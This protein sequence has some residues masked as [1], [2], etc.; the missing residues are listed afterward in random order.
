MK[1]SGREPAARIP[2]PAPGRLDAPGIME[3]FAHRMM[4][5]VAKDEHTA[6]GFDVFQALAF[7]VRDRLMERWFRTQSA[8]YVA[9][10]KR[11]Y[12]LS[13]E[14]L[15]GRAL[16]HNVINLRAR[17][18]YTDA[19]R[20]VGYDLEA[21]QEQEW[22]AGLGNG[23]LGRLAA[24]ILDS[25]ATLGLPFY[26]YGIR[27]EYGIFQQ[28][29]RDGFQVES[30]D[31]W[32]RYGN[33][34]E[35]PRADAIFPVRFYGRAEHYRD[36]RGS[37]RAAWVDTQE[38]WA[39]AYDTPVTGFGNDTVNTLRL[40][41]AKSS[42]EFDLQSFNAGE[43]VRA[44]EDKTSSENISKVLY[45]PDD[46]YAG[47]ELRLKQQYFFV[48]ATLQDVLRRFRKRSGRSWRELPDKVR[49]QLNDTHPVLAIPELMRLLVD[50]HHVDWDQAWELTQAVFAYTNHTVLPEALEKWPA[51]LLGRLLPRHLEIVEEIDRRFRASVALQAGADQGLVERTAV[52][53][54]ARNVRMAHL[55]FVGSRFVNGV[56]ALHTRI[57]RESTFAELDRVAPGR[58]QN[59]TNG[60][61]PRRWLLLANP[62]LAS[63]VT[64][65]IGDRWITDLDEL[66][67]LAPLAED[68][69]FREQWAALKRV[70]K[71]VLAD[72]VQGL[73]GLTLDPDSLFDFQVKRI[74]EYKRQL[75]NVLHV[76]ALHHRIRDGRYE[77]GPRTV[78]FA[79]KAAPGY[80]MAKRIIKLIHAVAEMVAFDSASSR[81]LRV[82]FVPNYSVSLAEVIFPACELSEQISTAGTEA[83]GTGNM[84]AALNGAL[85]IG[86][87]DGANVEIRDQVG[88]DNFFLFGN[89][90]EQ[91]AALRASGDSPGPF[92]GRSEALRRAIEAI[93]SGPLE[94]TNPGAFR[95]IVEELRGPDR[96][97]VCADFDSYAEAQARVADR[98]ATTP[99]DWWRMSVLNVAGM[100]TFSSDRTTRA[101]AEEIW[102]AQPVR[103]KL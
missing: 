81:L 94:W 14:F 59:K 61:T 35:I 12:Y 63:L 62:G 3:T 60:I 53:D 33:P 76:I 51:D 10:V 29:I 8:Y 4:Y 88:A 95:P 86:T 16:V 64:E 30:P 20:R 24:C 9:D 25:A 96:Y 73:H 38:V 49:I 7:A 71:A 92:I 42:R 37:L 79:G 69:A 99:D 22:D 65:A 50:E 26:G 93:E 1:P 11:V 44:V 78:L 21:L 90:T 82:V 17:D 77:G 75:L 84:K 72:R 18:A 34:W 80:A 15:M 19:L 46:Q 97:C 52:I 58:I 101:Y 54:G 85:T 67:R 36:E 5:S 47:K 32:L 28:R 31:N 98:Y 55:A 103:V 48:C 2:Q 70:N 6:T 56:A 89:T 66:R 41:S 13:L 39:M 87:L 23:G 27:Y 40:W 100:G 68:A 91:V 43:Y 45:P 83:S 74:H 102:Q 57:L